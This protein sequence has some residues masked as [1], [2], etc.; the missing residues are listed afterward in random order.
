MHSQGKVRTTGFKKNLIQHSVSGW[1]EED[2]VKQTRAMP[3][4][5]ADHTQLGSEDRVVT[6]IRTVIV[7]AP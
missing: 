1:G 4:C 2:T 5:G 6:V 7:S 3:A